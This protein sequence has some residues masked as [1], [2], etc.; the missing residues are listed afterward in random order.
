VKVVLAAIRYP[1]APGGAETH[2]QAIAAGLARRG[3]DVVVHTSDLLT[4]YPFERRADLPGEADGVRI[5]RHRAVRVA[6]AWTVMPGLHRAFLS[7]AR[8]ADVL[9]AHSYGYHQTVVAARVA[10]RLGKPLVLTPHYHP[11][12]SMEGG[13]GRRGLR[14]VFDAALG[15][16]VVRTAA[17]LVA[18]SRG[19]LD[20]MSRRLPVRRERVA[21]IPNGFEAERYRE[22]PDGAAFRKR[23]DLPGRAPLVVYAGRLAS[24]KGL[25][26][27]I[28]AFARVRS[29]ARLVLAGQ[30]QGWRAR[31]E[32]QAR[33]RGVLERVTFTAHLDAPTYRAALAA[34]DVFALLS[35]WEAFG[36]VLL[37]AAAS[38]APSV[39]TRVGGT[40]DVVLDGETGYL[41]PY[42]DPAA[43][44]D[45][46]GRLLDDEPLRSR[47]G[48]AARARALAAPSWDDVVDRT[49]DVYASVLGRRS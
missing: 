2:V 40:S 27:L 23:F 26:T 11:P 17:V 12:W 20:E 35:E 43:A 16:R 34:A 19:E 9:H 13:A 3:H 24:N 18:V 42:G 46:I 48:A 33:A 21:V 37:E 14:S 15:A 28:D 47:M 36:I 32:A 41:V 49:L 25:P 8:G 1:P 6:G 45:A 5:V 44:A 31:L 38:G 4:E 29:D 10:R 30:D 22:R 39:A 7:D